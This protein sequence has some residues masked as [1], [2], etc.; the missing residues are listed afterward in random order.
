MR[1]STFSGSLSELAEQLKR[2]AAAGHT[3]ISCVILPHYPDAEED[4]ARVMAAA[5]V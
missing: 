1:K 2:S 5:R 4:W 3:G